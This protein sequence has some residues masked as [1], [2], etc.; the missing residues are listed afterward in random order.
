MYSGE[1]ERM[2]GKVGRRRRTTCS[3]EE[4]RMVGE[5]GGRKRSGNEEI[6]VG[7]VGRRGSRSPLPKKKPSVPCKISSIGR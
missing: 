2:V 4:Q 1:E 7:E 6:M 3:G 5:V